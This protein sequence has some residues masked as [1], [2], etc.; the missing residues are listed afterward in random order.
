V[1]IV[2]LGPPGAGK[3]TQ[4]V[5]IAERCGVP[6][7][8]T[9]DMLRD[10]VARSSEIGG[11]AGSYMDRGELVPDEV[12]IRMLRQR[13][14]EPDA[15]DGFVLDGFPRTVPQAQALD[16][17]LLSMAVPLDHV[18][19]IDPADAE[20]VKR[21]SLRRTCPT[22]G[23]AY[24]LVFSPPAVDERCD[25]DDTPLIQREDDRAEVVQN[26]LDVYRR[27]TAPVVDYYDAKGLVRRVDP[28]GTQAEVEERIFKELDCSKELQ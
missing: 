7:I 15:V 1:R 25:V 24:N 6:K 9:G 28:L 12:L 2:L 18:L 22:C 3:G 11:E 5:A 13:V 26:R 19:L 4:A 10:E 8:S 27:Q 16:G 14:S 23:R 17:M 20:I 21:I